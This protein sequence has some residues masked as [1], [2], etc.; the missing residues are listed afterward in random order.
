[1]S[2]QKSLTLKSLHNDFNVEFE[3]GHRYLFDS[4]TGRLT[5]FLNGGK[6]P[7][8]LGRLYLD[9]GTLVYERRITYQI[10]G[11]GI[12][13]SVGALLLEKLA[14]LN[15]RIVYIEFSYNH[16]YQANAADLWFGR[17]AEKVHLYNRRTDF[18]AQYIIPR[19]HFAFQRIK[20]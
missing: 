4:T 19:S 7:I 8:K 11:L 17:F 20:K 9:R 13:W 12:N 1:M 14:N 2:K 3:N 6:G 10:H 15:A 18:E 5:L 16:K